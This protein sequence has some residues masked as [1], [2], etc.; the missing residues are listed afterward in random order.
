MIGDV[1]DN[2]GKSV[3]VLGIPVKL[4]DTPGSIRTAPVG[5]G[6]STKKILEEL[7][8]TER[9]IEGFMEKGVV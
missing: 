5:F 9:E 1:K 8:Y 4:S 7:G 6:E 2:K 3:K